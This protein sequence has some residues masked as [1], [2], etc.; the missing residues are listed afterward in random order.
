MKSKYALIV[1]L[2]F[3]LALVS[4]VIAFAPADDCSAWVVGPMPPPPCEMTK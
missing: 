2:L 3:V 4:F 1:A